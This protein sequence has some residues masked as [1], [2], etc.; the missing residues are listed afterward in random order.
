MIEERQQRAGPSASATEAAR[1]TRS[2]R[3][4]TW[5]I[6]DT[7]MVMLRRV[8]RSHGCANARGWGYADATIRLP[9][10]QRSVQTL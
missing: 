6:S 1:D 4:N 8:L 3:S 2:M 10:H 7:G 5:R 9:P